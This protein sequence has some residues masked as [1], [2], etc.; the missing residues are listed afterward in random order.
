M[1]LYSFHCSACD[2]DSEL[3]M[4]SDE[5]AI[6]PACGSDKM[7]RLPSWLAPD[8]KLEKNRKLWRAKA[9]A[10]GHLSNFSKKEQATFK[11]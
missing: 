10:E 9:A 1:P 11:K 2:A 3:L 7:E 5:A 6:C 8:M 4:R